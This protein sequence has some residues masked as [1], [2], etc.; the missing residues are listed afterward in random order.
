MEWWVCVEKIWKGLEEDMV[1][2][3]LIVEDFQG[4]VDTFGLIL[5][6]MGALKGFEQKCELRK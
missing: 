3:D 1:R 2:K 6:V 4:W 5:R